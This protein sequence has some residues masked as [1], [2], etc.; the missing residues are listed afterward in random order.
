MN[1]N[2]VPI[3]GRYGEEPSGRGNSRCKGPGVGMSMV[4]LSPGWGR[5]MRK[6]ECVEDLPEEIKS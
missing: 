4:S 1:D 2:K 5:G 6:R 3:I